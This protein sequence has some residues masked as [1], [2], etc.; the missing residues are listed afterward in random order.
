MR[1]VKYFIGACLLLGFT[2]CASFGT[3]VH[4]ITP[5]TLPSLKKIAIWPVAAVPLVDRIDE[6]H[7][8]F[9]DSLLANYADFRAQSMEI[10]KKAESVLL[11]ELNTSG[12][13][14]VIG[15]DSVLGMIS[16]RNPDYWRFGR[17]DWKSYKDIV[18]ATGFLI[19]KLSF[20]RESG[21]INTYVTLTIYDNVT[22]NAIIEAKFNTKWGKSY[23]LPQPMEKT[24]PDGIH[25]AVN[26]LINELRK[27]PA[28]GGTDRG[29]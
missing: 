29:N 21:G 14:S 13:F 22:G 2:S 3:K 24:L 1:I 9:V 28:F 18:D 4:V 19:T 26:G 5:E 15:P 10:S 23:L 7:P 27:H 12:L 20:G 17:E 8:E 6:K 25:G 16:D 11:E